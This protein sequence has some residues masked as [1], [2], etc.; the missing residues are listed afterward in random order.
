[1]PFFVRCMDGI[2][3][4]NKQAG[5]TSFGV[6]AAVRRICGER[7]AG[8]AGTLDPMARGVLP[9]CLGRAT[10]VVEYFLE[11]KKTY[12][13]E[14]RLGTAT[15]TGDAEGAVILS[16]DP[17]PVTE[18]DVV[19]VLNRFRGEIRQIPPMFSAI[20][21]SGRPLYKFAR[22]GK[23]V[24]RS[25]RIAMIYDIT[26]RSWR[27]PVATIEVTC[28][29]GTY[30]RVLAE[31]VGKLLGC[32]AHLVSL[33][34]TAYGPLDVSSAISLPELRRLADEGQ[35]A[36][37]L[38]PIDSVLQDWPAL[39]ADDES[40]LLIKHGR[41]LSSEHPGLS[42]DADASKRRGRCRVYAL[43]GCFLGM[44]RFNSEKSEWQPEKVFA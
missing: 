41:A 17:S 2:L 24:E 5:D 40:A 44:L 36:R 30:M 13:A 7:R 32:G 3:N 38:L 21:H 10:R 43:D 35:C 26:L 16:A 33:V 8:H 12:L 19:N 31:D 28:G 4:I 6:V 20:K 11:A 34:R 27:P 18:A 14:V 25:S 37:V 29:R 23:S 15:D 1:M 22:E 42:G 9:V 39:V